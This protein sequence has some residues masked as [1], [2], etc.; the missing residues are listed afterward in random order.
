MNRI[1]ELIVSIFF[2]IISIVFI[3]GWITRAPVHSKDDLYEVS[4]KIKTF[5]NCVGNKNY[6]YDYYL[7]VENIPADFAIKINCDP[8]FNRSKFESYV[9]KGAL[10]EIYIA[11]SEMNKLSN[12]KQNIYV[13]SVIAYNTTLL[14]PSKCI[15]THNEYYP[16]IFAT[17]FGLIGIS[18]P[19]FR[20]Y[21]Y[22]KLNDIKELP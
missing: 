15:K 6:N 2:I 8:S 12:P 17:V 21:R 5:L 9:T 7:T 13:F 18:V 11:K 16:L 4:G 20:Y 14:D 1:T 22:R 10:V 19:V 3:H